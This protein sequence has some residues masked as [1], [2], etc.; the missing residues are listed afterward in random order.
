MT[1]GLWVGLACSLAAGAATGAVTYALASPD[2]DQ[3]AVPAAGDRVRA[4]VAELREDRVHVPP[5]GRGLLDEAGERRLERLAAASDPAVHVVVWGR[6]TNAGYYDA[7]EAAQQLAPRVGEDGIVVVWEGPG[8]GEVLSAGGDVVVGPY[9]LPFRSDWLGD[10][11][12]QL[13]RVL[14]ELRGARIVPPGED[15]DSRSGDVV[16]GV[17]L[18]GVGYAGLLTF[19]GVRR[20][21][22][23]R[24][25]LVP[26][27]WR[28]SP[29]TPSTSRRRRDRR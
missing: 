10:P 29:T 21:W 1:P 17:T 18:A 4:A 11:E 24:P 27:P 26:G 16:A 22:T 19:V 8:R 13:V 3:V 14:D 7:R 2:D 20:W 5:D 28:R 15:D 6:T 9:D 23:G 12:T 25:F